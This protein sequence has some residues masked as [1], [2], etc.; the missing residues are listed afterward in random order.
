MDKRIGVTMYPRLFK[1]KL[2][3]LIVLAATIAL[4][5][6]AGSAVVAL[7]DSAPVTYY[8]CLKNGN[9][10]NVDTSAPQN[11]P[12]GATIATW[13]QVGPMGPAGMQGEPGPQGLTGAQGP[14][15]DTGAAGVAGPQG[16]KGDTGATGPQGTKG[17]TGD[18]GATGAPGPQGPEGPQG[19]QGPAGSSGLSG[20]YTQSAE[21]TATTGTGGS[22]SV[23]CHSGDVVIGGGFDVTDDSVEMHITASKPTS[24]SNGTPGW[25]VFYTDAGLQNHEYIVYAICAAP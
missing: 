20:T 24:S 12:N 22:G 9:L 14:K 6:A 13:N 17:D 5:F 21:F 7:G 15:G 18:T 11:C 10:T 23:Y 8:G 25:K 19:L 2:L 1:S 4:A 16:P 3:R